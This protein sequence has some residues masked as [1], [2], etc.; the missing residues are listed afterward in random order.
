ME[1]K[2]EKKLSY[3]N[4]IEILRYKNVCVYKHL[5]DFT[6]TFLNSKH[7][8]EIAG[9]K[10]PLKVNDLIYLDLSIWEDCHTYICGKVIEVCKTKIIIDYEYVD[11]I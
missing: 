5:V 10:I 6:S 1:L 7:Q 3:E 8:Y 4:N 9:L 2:I 11:L